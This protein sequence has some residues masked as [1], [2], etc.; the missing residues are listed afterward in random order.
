ME[1]I[2]RD[3]KKKKKNGTEGG[4]TLYVQKHLLQRD[5]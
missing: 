4:F 3:L 5:F 2:K 1:G